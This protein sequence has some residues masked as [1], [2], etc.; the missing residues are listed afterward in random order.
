MA[1]WSGRFQSL[2]DRLL[3]ERFESQLGMNP[4]ETELTAEEHK[5]T[6]EGRARRAFKELEKFCV[7]SEALESL[8]DFQAKFAREKRMLDLLAPQ[9]LIRMSMKPIIKKQDM[10]AGH[11][12][13]GSWEFLT[14]AVDHKLSFM[15]KLMGKSR[16]GS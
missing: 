3:W 13:D 4:R 14:K 12:S 15:D 6:E 10:S 5:T 8:K 16:K 11:D 1:Y 9:K 7:T 2:S